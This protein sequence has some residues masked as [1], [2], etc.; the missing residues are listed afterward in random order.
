MEGFRSMKKLICYIFWHKW[1]AINSAVSICQRCGEEN[2]EI[3]CNVKQPTGWTPEEEED[4]DMI[5]PWKGI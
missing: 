3:I 2:R 5:M 4:D 1:K